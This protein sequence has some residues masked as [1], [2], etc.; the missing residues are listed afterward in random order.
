MYQANGYQ[1]WVRN[2]ILATCR[3]VQQRSY[4]IVNFRYI[5]FEFFDEN[6][7][8]IVIN[9]NWPAGKL[10]TCQHTVKKVLQC[11]GL[12]ARACYIS[13]ARN[14]KEWSVI[15]NWMQECLCQSTRGVRKFHSVITASRPSM[16]DGCY[17]ACPRRL[18]EGCKQLAARMHHSLEC[19]SSLMP[20]SVLCLTDPHSMMVDVPFVRSFVFVSHRNTLLNPRAWRLL[21]KYKNLPVVND[22]YCPWGLRGS[23]Y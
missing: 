2:C 18:C 8:F 1:T 15:C 10:L 23:C 5:H 16:T 12:Y 4:L 21:R 7:C 19:E 17:I 13:C 6:L 9:G 14:R 3:H 20:N 11:N 22:S